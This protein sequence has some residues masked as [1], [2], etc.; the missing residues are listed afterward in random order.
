MIFSAQELRSLGQRFNARFHDKRGER[1][2]TVEAGEQHG[3]TWVRVLLRNDDDSFHY[4]VEARSTASTKK[5]HRAQAFFLL[6]FLDTYWEEF[7]DEDENVFV[8]IDWT[9]YEYQGE[10]FQIRGQVLNRMAEKIADELLAR[11]P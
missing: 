5:S 8:P 9:F 3:A 11:Q 4:P 1:W 2:F 6:A 7:F 10:K